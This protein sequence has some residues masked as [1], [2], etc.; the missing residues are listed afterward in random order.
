M[1]DVS[2]GIQT[3]ETCE[4]GRSWLCSNLSLL[5]RRRRH[6]RDRRGHGL[7]TQ[8]MMNNPGIK[9]MLIKTARAFI[10]STFVVEAESR[11]QEE[12]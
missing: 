9:T 11:K 1:L 6:I 10:R 2:T 7:T 4:S 5:R 3:S 8:M 12:R